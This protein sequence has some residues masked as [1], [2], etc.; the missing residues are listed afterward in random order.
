MNACPLYQQ[1]RYISDNRKKPPTPRRQ[2]RR[3][4]TRTQ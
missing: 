1:L 3:R 2:P 4:K